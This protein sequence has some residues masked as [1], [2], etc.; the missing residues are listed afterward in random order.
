MTTTDIFRMLKLA[1][2]FLESFKVKY[3]EQYSCF[4]LILQM[5]VD[6]PDPAISFNDQT[7]AEEAIASAIQFAMIG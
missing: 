7:T 6:C 1:Y 4:N 5:S 2:P 3:D